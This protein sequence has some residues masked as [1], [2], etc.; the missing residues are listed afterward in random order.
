MEATESTAAREGT[1][2]RRALLLPALRLIVSLALVAWV[3]HRARFAEVADAF[4]SADPWPV[5]LALALNPLGTWASVSRWRLLLRTRGVDVPLGS[6]VRAFLVGVFFNNLLPST[7][8][9]DAVRAWESSRAGA[10]RSTAV[11]VVL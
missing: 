7:I 2:K 6:L 5:L 11:A 1:P 10:D 9:G 3:F 8:G 4:R